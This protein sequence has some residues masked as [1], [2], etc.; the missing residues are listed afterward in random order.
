MLRIVNYQR[1]SAAAL[2]ALMRWLFSA[3]TL[4]KLSSKAAS[5]GCHERA[6]QPA[7]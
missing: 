1:A 7:A 5:V 4:Q 6:R 2:S 3:E